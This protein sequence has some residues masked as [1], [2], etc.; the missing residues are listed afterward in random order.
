MLPSPAISPPEPVST[1]SGRFHLDVMIGYCNLEADC[2]TR[3][4]RDVLETL[5]M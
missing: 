1:C 3:D 2:P 4:V 5:R